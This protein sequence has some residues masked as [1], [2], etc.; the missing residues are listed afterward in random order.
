[1][2]SA[3]MRVHMEHMKGASYLVS[4]GQKDFPQQTAFKVIGVTQV[5]KEE[6]R[7]LL[8]AEGRACAKTKS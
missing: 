8:Q 6:G 4:G 1:M 5:N 2:E 7:R 3:M